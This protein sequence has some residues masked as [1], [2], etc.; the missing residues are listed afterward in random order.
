MKNALLKKLLGLSLLAAGTGVSIYGT[1]SIFNPNPGRTLREA[2]ARTRHYP[3]TTREGLIGTTGDVPVDNPTDNV[4]H[5]ALREPLRG[6]DKVYLVYELSGV[7]D[8]TAVSRSVN[9]RLAVG[10]YLVSK[11]KGWALQREKL[12]ADWLKAGDN[13]IRFSVPGGA[14]HSY[15]VRNLALEVEQ[16]AAPAAEP[17]L[18]VNQPQGHPYYQN[19]AY[20]KGFVSGAGSEAAQVLVDGQKVRV[21]QGEFEGIVRRNPQG[22]SAAWRVTVQAVYP[23]GRKV[24]EEVEFATRQA[25]HYAYPLEKAVSTARQGFA[26]HQAAS[27]GLKGTAL[28]ATAG[29]LRAATTLSVTALREVDIPALD[30]GMVNVTRYSAGFRYLP[31]GTQFAR[32]ARLKVA[33]D[34]QKIPEGYTAQDI[35]TYFFDEQTHHWVPLPTDTVLAGQATVV[36]RTTHF[37]DM[38]NAIIKVP[39]SPE[40]AA[41]N[42]NSIKGIK[43]ANPTAAVNLLAPPQATHT[44]KASTGYPLNLPAGRNGMQPQLGINYNSGGGNGWLGLNWNLQ[45][46]AVTIDTRWGVP[47]YDGS[48]ETETYT[49]NGEQ[50]A[51]VAHRGALQDRSS[52]KQFY[53]RVEGAFNRIIRRGSGPKNYWWEV[54]DKSGVKYC[55]GGTTASGLDDKAVLT[56]DQGNVA[57]WALVETRDLDGN[58]VR[59]HYDKVADAGIAGGTVPGYQ[60]YVDKITYTGYGSTEGKYAVLFTRDRDLN[61]PRRKDVAISANLGFKLVTADLL[62]KVDVQFEGQPVRSYALQYREGAFYKTLLSSISEYDAGG[63]LFN[64]HTFDYYDDVHAAKGYKPFTAAQPWTARRDSING[65]FINPIN[66]FG[67]EASALSGTKSKDFSVG[68]AVTVGF[69]PNV[70][71]KSFSV[72]GNVGYSQSASEG[73]L[74]L[75]DINGDALPDKV[76]VKNNGMSYRANLSKPGG[77]PAFSDTLRSISGNINAFHKEKSK[78]VSGGVEAHGPAPLTVF[79][80]AGLSTTTS[81]TTVYFAEV[82]GDLLTDVVVNGK[83]YFNHLDSGGNVV[84]T[85]SSGDTPSPINPGGNVAAD[86]LKVDPAEKEK[87][88]DQNPLH[89]V[90]RLWRAPYSGTVAVTAPVQLLKSNDPARGESPADGVRVTIQHKGS[91]IWSTT[92]GPD[93]YAVHT[94]T[95]VSSLTV[96]RGDQLYFRVQSVENGSF[97]QVQWSPVIRYLGQDENLVDANGKNLYRFAAA[98]DFLLSANQVVTTP[99][100]GRVKIGD[101]FR[102]PV[103]TDDVEASIVKLVKVG[104]NL[105]ETVVEKR[106]YAWHQ[107]VNEPITLE[108]DVEAFESYAFRVKSATNIDWNAVG[109]TPR[110]YYTASYDASYPKVTDAQGNPL[111]DAY[112]VPECSVF[113]R[114]LRE[115][116]PWTVPAAA[117]TGTLSVSPDLSFTSPTLSGQVTFTVKKQDTLLLKQTLPVLNGAA[118]GGPF[119]I[120]AITGGNLYFEFHLAGKELAR[121]LHAGEV[122][123]AAGDS[124]WQAPAGVHAVLDDNNNDEDVIFGPLYRGWGHFAYNGN[125]DRAARP[126]NEAELKI[127]EAMKKA[128]DG[129]KDPGAVQD[130]TELENDQ[131]YNPRKELFIMLLPLA[132]EAAWTG[133]DKY[134][135]VGASTISSSRMGDDDLSAAEALP[136]GSGARAVNKISKSSAR[137][138]SAGGSFAGIGGSYGKSIGESRLVIDFMDMNGDRYPDIVTDER[139][140]YTNAAGGLSDQY[141]DHGAG[142]NHLTKSESDGVTLSGSFP[143]SEYEGKPYNP[144]KVTVSVGNGQSSAGLSGNFAKGSNAAEYSYAD[145][146]G[147]ALPDRVYKGGQVALNLGYRFAPAEQWGYA[148][149]QS[150][151]SRSF[152]AGLGVSLVNG[153]IS[154]GIGL[155]RSDNHNRKALQDVN[156]DGLADEVVEGNPVRVRLNTGNGFGESIPW[157]G[158]LRVSESSSASES[159]NA[160]FTVGV[161][162]PIINIKICFNPSTSLGQGMSRDLAKLGDVNGDGYPDYLVSDQDDKLTVAVSTIGRTNLLKRVQRPLG[163]SFALDYQRHGNTYEMPVDVWALSQ[164]VVRDGFEGDGVDSMRT[165][166]AYEDGYYDRHE[167]EFY[168][169]GKVTTRLHDTGQADPGNVYSSVA[170]TFSNDN[171][172]TKGLPL[173]ETMQD[174]EGRKYSRKEHKYALRDVVAGAV[175]FPALIQTAEQFY[176]GQPDP[177]KQTRVGFGYDRYGNMT[178]LTDEGDLDSKDDDLHAAVAYHYLEDNYI[179]GTPKSIVVTGSGKTYRKRECDIDD[180]GNVKQ[181]RQFLESGEASRFDLDYDGYGN[182]TKVTRP[183]NHKG[184]RL[185]LEY[186]YDKTVHTYVESTVNSYNY[187]SKAAYDF[188]F[189]ALLSTTDLNNNE[190]RYQ[191]DNLGRVTRITG[192]YELKAG[193]PYTILFE[194][195]P[196]A[197]VPWALTKHYDPANPANPLETSTFVDG[198]GRVLQTKK[199]AAL[200]QGDNALDKEQMLVSGRVLFDAFGRTTHA[201]YPI[202]ENTGTAGVFNKG[203]DAVKPTLSTYDVLDRT[204][205]VTLPDGAATQTAYGFAP[206]RKGVQQFST[207]TTDANGTV[208]EQ[209]TDTRDRVTAVKNYTSDGDVWTSFAY[210]AVGEQLEATDDQGHTT[211]SVYDWLGRRVRRTHPDA[212]ETTYAYDLAGNLTSLQTANLKSSGGAVA[213][214]YEFER[215][216]TVTYPENPENNVRYTYGQAGATDNRAGRVVLQEDASGAQEFFYGPLGEVLRNVRTVVIPKHDAQTYTTQWVYDTWNRL[217]SMTYADGEV[218]TYTY[219]AGGLLRGMT[220]KKGTRNYNYVRQLGYDKFEQRVFLAYG[221]G[222]KTTYAYEPDR[223]RLQQMTARTAA[224]RVMMNNAYGYDKVNNILSL[225]NTAPVPPSNLM[226]GPGEYGYQYDDLYRLTNATGYFRGATEQHRYA[227]QMNYNSV[228]GLTRKHQKHERSGGTGGSWVEQHKT[229][230]QQAYDYSDE[231]P[232]AP[233][234]VGKQAYTYDANGN[235]TGWTH[236][237]SG[238]RRKIFWDEENR[239]RAIMDNGATYHYVYD[240]QGERVLKGHSSGQAVYANNQHKSG[241]GNM[242]NYTVYVNPYLV[243]RSGGYTK[244]YYIESQRIVSK[245]G[246]GWDN[247]G[248]GP[249]AAPKAGGTGVNYAAKT[250]QV[251]DGLVR[252]LKNLGI[253]GA[254]MTAVKSNK[255]PPGQMAG[256]AGAGTAETFQYYFHPDHL[257]STSYVTDVGGE[258]YQ[259]L[260]YFAFG[261]T[262]VEEHSNTHRTPYLFN[263]KELDD[264]TGLYYYGARY[265]DPR[266]SI[267]QS[268][269]PLAEKYPAWNPYCY[270]L[271]NPVKLID[272]DGRE[273]DEPWYTRASAWVGN[274][275]KGTDAGSNQ[276]YGLYKMKGS[277]T[278]GDTRFG[279]QDNAAGRVKN[280]KP[281]G[282]PVIRFDVADKRTPYPHINVNPELTGKPD[283][284]YKIP[285]GKGT[286]K[287]LEVAGKTLNTVGKVAKP[288]AIATDAVRI[289]DAVRADGGQVGNQTIK[290]TASVA[291][292]WVGAA[293]GA[294]AG[295][296]G[297]AL[298]GGAIGAWFG[299]VGAVPGAAVGGF[300]GGL[301]GGIYG[302]FKGAEWSEKAADAL[303]K[304]EQ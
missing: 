153:S 304:P 143:T 59:Y 127:S 151:D 50:L 297:G 182:L 135:Y 289:V 209:F 52:N 113:A 116:K 240:A 284:H 266:T 78:T 24:S 137:S 115:S 37:T 287:T 44:G 270:A 181:I 213:Y 217:T 191:L 239:I 30:A 14:R 122:T 36:S 140:Q 98:E 66:A 189:G 187:V 131:T 47:R 15:R 279:I 260:E 275:L 192:P 212:G 49:L 28:D 90:V 231:Q 22:A 238:Q 229:T 166:F 197:T 99:I 299:G 56:D 68:V 294:A 93:D 61:E 188:R 85:A 202:T 158:A 146:N 249:I 20:V 147:D 168:G 87:A 112:A 261:E 152:G 214:A 46:P 300:L 123:V 253:D 263:G 5:V 219:N 171:Y 25:A 2:V 69:D 38:I 232:H 224:N 264:E 84:F 262:F 221:N 29:S 282:A 155:S 105:V 233:V 159:V 251:V 95:G 228:G 42:S 79:A 269:D 11:R 148:E 298:A 145:I 250:Q 144:K 295:A 63:K 291:G 108:A 184:E 41:Y 77:I 12:A 114:A 48:K 117:S 190:T 3:A 106:T 235:Q 243:L 89:D 205:S 162:F 40:V 118:S 303:L 286:L 227:M 64:T 177:G 9:D 71:T 120:P 119:V 222:T 241:S 236:D 281:V 157:A 254:V 280:G 97:D 172:F 82:N 10:G 200:Y 268:I 223:R 283:P 94:P 183:A 74:S 80:G 76:F 208:T 273:P 174:G 132:K 13:V 245:L 150:G 154:A 271:N 54:T 125:R 73:L 259:H 167:R 247:N 196:A 256:T 100:K 23:D 138:F 134:T 180:T 267:F 33:Y 34:E 225:K 133:A 26:P 207:R 139:I 216:L 8:H 248:K 186:T 4:F 170:E 257:G 121:A 185:S 179:V 290:T 142:V 83:V 31:H 255:V 276:R 220:G 293:A 175:V 161:Y 111:I 43:A 156:G 101:T 218:V 210:N 110:L 149:I 244:H 160:A 278:G 55:Y 67:D 274:V 126:I 242:G 58:F 136:G 165:T 199:D 211:A 62:R 60:L 75:I 96:Q 51:P 246:S 204:L 301:G 265:Y 198:L 230:Y 39:E 70:A 163:A 6:D 57:Y 86:I 107:E 129:Y 130:G 19:Q 201:Y 16:A 102:K 81:T 141:T 234:H 285:G 164:V 296:K 53:P 272:P 7:A 226:G 92:I 45:T 258:V 176:E 21:F 215:L 32:E 237:V 292:G 27:I 88:I 206:D 173:S 302:S 178:T 203:F 109:W 91:E 72:G 65:G 277:T 288:V 128:K 252:N 124:T 35:K 1:T 104:D 193:A 195:Y 18:V 103:T 17:A 194:Y 169:F